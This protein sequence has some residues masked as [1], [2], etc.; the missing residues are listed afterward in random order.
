MVG[1]VVGMN[2]VSQAGSCLVFVG[3]NGG[4]SNGLGRSVVVAPLT[5]AFAVW[6][7]TR[8]PFLSVVKGEFDVVVTRCSFPSGPKVKGRFAVLV[9]W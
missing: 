1:K 6:T 3:V 4:R 7:K 2:L 8:W 5:P 9:T